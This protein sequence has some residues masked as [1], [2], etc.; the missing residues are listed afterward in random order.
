MQLLDWKYGSCITNFFLFVATKPK[1]TAWSF[2][3]GLAVK[4]QPELIATAES[5]QQLGKFTGYCVCH[6]YTVLMF[7]LGHLL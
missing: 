3:H 5:I 6:K 4:C 2:G 7:P 1:D